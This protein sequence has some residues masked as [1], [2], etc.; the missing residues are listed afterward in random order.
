MQHR[1]AH[2]Q[3]H[4]VLYAGFLQRAVD[5]YYNFG[6]GQLK[7]LVREIS[8]QL[9][10]CVRNNHSHVHCFPLIGHPHK[11]LKPTIVT[12]AYLRASL[13]GDETLR[14]PNTDAHQQRLTL[15]ST[16][17]TAANSSVSPSLKSLSATKSYQP[18]CK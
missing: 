6:R 15:N 1:L 11:S 10:Y 2:F 3:L 17:P 8:T 18:F 9:K 12:G 13:P 4:K 7:C 5:H 14:R 16:V